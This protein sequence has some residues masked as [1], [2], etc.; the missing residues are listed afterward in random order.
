L[1]AARVW[2]F[3]G[4]GQFVLPSGSGS[5]GLPN[6]GC[7]VLWSEY[8]GLIEIGAA[9]PPSRRAVDWGVVRTQHSIGNTRNYRSGGAGDGWPPRL[10][11]ARVVGCVG[12][13]RLVPGWR[14][15]GVDPR[16]GAV[17]RVLC[18][19]GVAVAC[20]GTGGPGEGSRGTFPC[21]RLVAATAC[22]EAHQAPAH[23][24]RWV[25]VNRLLVL[26]ARRSGPPAMIPTAEHVH[27]PRK[28]RNVRGRREHG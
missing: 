16:R 5:G 28:E 22:S 12:V 2:I 18:V 25:S 26:P 14:A 13:R 24:R 9:G 11:G 10:A 20:E 23:A 19:G 7:V 27:I 3:G 4:S 1:R 8:R 17:V 15:W 6:C 21:R